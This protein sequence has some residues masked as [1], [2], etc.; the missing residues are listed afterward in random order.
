[1]AEA[2]PRSSFRGFDSHGPSMDAARKRAADAGLADRVGFDVASATDFPGTDYDLIC[3]FDSFHD[4]GN[5]EDAA[6]Q[7]RR[8][9]AEDGTLMLV[10][11]YAGDRLEDN[12][13]PVGRIFYSASTTIC[14]FVS[15]SQDRGLALG[16]QAGEAKL[17]EV[18]RNAR[19]SSIRRAA[20]TP[21][22]MVL[23]AQPLSGCHDDKPRRVLAP[24]SPSTQL[25]RAGVD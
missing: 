16:A 15:K 6:S 22:N 2:F 9:V 14:T 4:L 20:E 3:F 13:T 12:L 17:S 10:E 23:Q 5:P 11:P 1:M 18:L 24:T 7:A 25:D 8:A 19:W 21:F